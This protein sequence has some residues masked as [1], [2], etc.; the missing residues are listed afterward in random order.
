MKPALLLVLA[1]S[2]MAGAAEPPAATGIVPAPG[3]DAGVDNRIARCRAK[4][5]PQQ[6]M[7]CEGELPPGTPRPA[8]SP[9]ASMPTR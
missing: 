6:R 8:A 4:A 9:K 5:D 7:A 1:L 3:A 2:G